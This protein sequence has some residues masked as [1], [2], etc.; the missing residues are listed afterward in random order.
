MTW[1]MARYSTSPR[2]SSWLAQSSDSTTTSSVS[3]PLNKCARWFAHRDQSLKSMSLIPISTRRT[4]IRLQTRYH[5]QMVS[6]PELV[7]RRR[8]PFCYYNYYQRGGQSYANCVQKHGCFTESLLWL[9]LM[10]VMDYEWYEVSSLTPV[11]KFRCKYIS[12]VPRYAQFCTYDKQDKNCN[13]QCVYYNDRLLKQQSVAKCS[14]SHKCGRNGSGFILLDF[15]LNNLY[16]LPRWDYM[17]DD[18][19]NWFTL[20][21]RHISIPDDYQLTNTGTALYIHID[22]RGYKIV[23]FIANA[24]TCGRILQPNNSQ[25]PNDWSFTDWLNPWRL[26][27]YIPV[28]KNT[29]QFYYSLKDRGVPASIF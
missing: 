19:S 26:D 14:S 11:E 6:I 22:G 23:N 7:M 29:D 2:L 24:N 25:D 8:C 15:V 13:T 28:I 16:A 12:S 27:D 3:H 5:V 4:D 21:G 9:E 10:D 17:I 18:L 20:A 1:P